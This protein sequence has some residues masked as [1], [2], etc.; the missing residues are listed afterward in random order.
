[1][2]CNFD[3]TDC[4]SLRIHPRMDYVD[5]HYGSTEGGE[6]IKIYGKGFGK[7]K[8]KVTVTAGG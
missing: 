1:M 7:D 2:H 5:K 4:W 3:N 6:K 8:K